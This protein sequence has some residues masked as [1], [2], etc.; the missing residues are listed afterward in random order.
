M[1]LGCYYL[2]TNAAYIT[3]K[4]QLYRELRHAHLKAR[5]SNDNSLEVY[6]RFDHKKMSRERRRY[7]V[8]KRVYIWCGLTL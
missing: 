3:R 4:E 2:T 7:N 8:L 5:E 1:T 6:G